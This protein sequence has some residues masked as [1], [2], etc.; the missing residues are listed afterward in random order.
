MSNTLATSGAP[1]VARDD[2]L[3]RETIRRVS[4][5]ILPFLMLAYLVCY[6]DRVN[7]GFAATQMNKAVGGSA[8]AFGFG[9]GIFFL[10]YCLFEVPSNL[11]LERFGARRWIARIMVSWGVVSGCMA[12]TAG[13]NSFVALRFLLGA[14]EAG[15]FSGVILYL[16][17]TAQVRRPR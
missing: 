9:G 13:P 5:R 11:V 2:A 4:W 10:S 14:A 12:L 1:D 7:A 3:G 15:F 17:V 16:T 8:A 6:I